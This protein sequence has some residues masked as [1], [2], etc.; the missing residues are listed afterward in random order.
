M[1]QKDS[2]ERKEAERTGVSRPSFKEKK[3]MKSPQTPEILLFLAGSHGNAN[4]MI[5]DKEVVALGT[6]VREAP[7]L[8]FWA[9]CTHKPHPLSHQR[10]AKRL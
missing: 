1:Y 2:S 8:Q 9:T 7:V 4:L 10:L 6:R 5:M 3:R